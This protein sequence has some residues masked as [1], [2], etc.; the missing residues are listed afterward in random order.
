MASATPFLEGVWVFRSESG[1]LASGPILRAFPEQLP[2]WLCLEALA[3][4]IPGYSGGTAPDS[5]RTSL[6]PPTYELDTASPTLHKQ[7]AQSNYLMSSSRV[8]RSSPSTMK[9]WPST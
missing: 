2:Q 6:D 7:L 1:L 8:A 9:A 3:N 4:D 5:H